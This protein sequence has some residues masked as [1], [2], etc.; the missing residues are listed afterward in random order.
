VSSL[1]D[2]VREI[3]L[4]LTESSYPWDL[5]WHANSSGIVA[6]FFCSALAGIACNTILLDQLQPNTLRI[7]MSF[8]TCFFGVVIESGKMIVSTKNAT[9][10]LFVASIA[11]GLIA[12][13]ILMF[14][15]G[16]KMGQAPSKTP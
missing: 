10:I 16:F 15:N 1:R 3:L 7:V 6:L 14:R 11:G 12:A 8:A 4:P 9:P 2:G 5:H 13:L